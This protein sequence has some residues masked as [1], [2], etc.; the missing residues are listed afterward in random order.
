MLQAEGNRQVTAS[1]SAALPSRGPGQAH[2]PRWPV[3]PAA[4]TV[5]GTVL[6][7]A[8]LSA[9]ISEAR[10]A[11]LC[12]VGERTTRA[13]EDGSRPLASVPRHSVARLQ[14]VLTRLGADPQI[15]ADFDAAMWCDLFFLGVAESGDTTCLLADPVAVSSS[16]RE[17]LDWCLTGS[18]PVRYQAYATPGPLVTDAALI[19]IATEILAALPDDAGI[20]PA[21]GKGR[22]SAEIV[23]EPPT[24]TP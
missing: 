20:W 4:G 7:A 16:F 13:W 23:D 5:A 6:H 15:V 24:A 14:A 2:E 22:D 18:V 12:R 19:K 9:G 3:P 17:M 11:Q 8:R 1:S 10:L 21:R